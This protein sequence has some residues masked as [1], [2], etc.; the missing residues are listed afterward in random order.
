MHEIRPYPLW[1]GHVGDARD[2]RGVLDRGITVL[3]DLAI[4]EPPVTLTHELAYC[5]FPLVDGA[6]NA[7]W[8]LRIAIETTRALI[9]QRVPTL[10]F[11]S[12]G[13][14][15]SPAI[16]AAALALVESRTVEETMHTIVTAIAPHAA[17]VSITLLGDIYRTL[18][19][20]KS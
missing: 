13:L 8:L 17:D 10:V 18:L 1:L 12:G 7:P 14:S 16:A 9:A 3:V 19:A 20:M 15:R 4:N 5:R 2:L 11:C 6:G